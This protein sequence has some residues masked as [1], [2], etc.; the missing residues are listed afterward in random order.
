MQGHVKHA[1]VKTHGLE[2]AHGAL[3]DAALVAEPS[4]ARAHNKVERAMGDLAQSEALAVG[5]FGVVHRGVHVPVI[6][7]VPCGV[8]VGR[9]VWPGSVEARRRARTERDGLQFL[10]RDV[11]N[12]PQQVRTLVHEGKA[13]VGPAVPAAIVKDGGVKSVPARLVR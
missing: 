4:L 2:A 11:V 1:L 12:V 7:A 10:S 6:R 3:D 13:G 9:R 5:A 8:R